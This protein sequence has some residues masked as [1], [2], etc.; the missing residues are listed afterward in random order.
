[1][2]LLRLHLQLLRQLLNDLLDLLLIF[3][4]LRTNLPDLGTGWCR[5]SVVAIPRSRL[6]ASLCRECHIKHEAC[7]SE[8]T[9]YAFFHLSVCNQK[10]RYEF[11]FDIVAQGS[12]E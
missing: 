6:G 3:N 12:R 8:L 9:P 11:L 5:Y 4:D 2:C 7:S 1:M 10:S